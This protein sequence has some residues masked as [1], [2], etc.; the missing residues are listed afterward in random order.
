MPCGR[1]SQLYDIK[2]N[3]SLDLQLAGSYATGEL[4][5]ALKHLNKI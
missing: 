2:N 5:M 4:E 1:L 3:I